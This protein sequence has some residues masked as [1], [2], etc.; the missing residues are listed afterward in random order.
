MQYRRA[1]EFI[2]LRGAQRLCCFEP[3]RDF[4]LPLRIAL[5]PSFAGKLVMSQTRTV[6]PCLAAHKEPVS[7]DTRRIV[8]APTLTNAN[9]VRK[10]STWS[11]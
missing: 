1:R 9:D 8:P 5:K 10:P 4:P 2:G 11:V 6:E 3:L 7:V